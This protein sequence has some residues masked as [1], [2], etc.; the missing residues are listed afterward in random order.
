MLLRVDPAAEG[1]LVP[2]MLNDPGVE[3]RRDAVAHLLSQADGLFSGKDVNETRLLQQVIYRQ[4][5]NAAR[6]D[7]Q[8]KVIVEKLKKLGVKLT[9]LAILDS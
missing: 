8:I 2:V 6:D 1:R 3:F 7:D 4:T 5:L 9:C